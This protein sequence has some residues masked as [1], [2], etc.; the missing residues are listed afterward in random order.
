MQLLGGDVAVALLE[1]E[2]GEGETLPGRPESG[3]TQAL[4]GIGERTHGDHDRNI[5]RPLWK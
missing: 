4:Q 5:V 1:Q 2:L 3:G